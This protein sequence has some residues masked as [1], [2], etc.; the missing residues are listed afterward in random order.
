MDTESH[1]TSRSEGCEEVRFIMLSHWLVAK[2]SN[3]LTSI[4]YNHTITVSQEPK[5]EHICIQ[6]AEKWVC[7]LLSYFN[8]IDVIKIKENIIWVKYI[9]ITIF[10]FWF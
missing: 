7:E 10:T 1:A 4:I 6:L 5:K 2:D 8:F 3:L 9:Y